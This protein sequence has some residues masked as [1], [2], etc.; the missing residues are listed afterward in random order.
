MI[1][2]LSPPGIIANIHHQV[3]AKGWWDIFGTAAWQA[4]GAE[5]IKVVIGEEYVSREEDDIRRGL[6]EGPRG[7]E[8]FGQRH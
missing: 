6:S 7:T 4:S 1:E 2:G 5:A 3:D 8:R